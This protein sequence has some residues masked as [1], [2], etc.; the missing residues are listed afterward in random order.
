MVFFKIKE[1]SHIY[2]VPKKKKKKAHPNVLFASKSARKVCLRHASLNELCFDH[3]KRS[4][5]GTLS[6]KCLGTHY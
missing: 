5:L 3:V 2:F 6:F 1:L 4:D